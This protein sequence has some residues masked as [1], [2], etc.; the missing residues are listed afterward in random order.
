MAPAPITHIFIE[1]RLRWLRGRG[2]AER[3]DLAPRDR[4]RKTSGPEW[5]GANV[6][7]ESRRVIFQ[8]TD[9]RAAPDNSDR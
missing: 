8:L 4:N 1:R 3:G 9:L 2:P 5:A 6:G 7:R